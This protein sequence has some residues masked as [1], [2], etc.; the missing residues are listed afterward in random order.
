MGI[1]SEPK[2]ENED[3]GLDE[4]DAF[5]VEVNGRVAVPKPEDA[6]AVDA[7]LRLS[8]EG[9]MR[10]LRMSSSTRRSCFC[11]D[12]ECCRLLSALVQD[13]NEDG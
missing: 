10:L 11:I 5:D 6:A 8:D 1:G 2:E 9:T 3:E 7:R 12:C 13:N 4:N